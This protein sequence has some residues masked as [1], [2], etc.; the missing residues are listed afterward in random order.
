MSAQENAE[1]TPETQVNDREATG[2]A[3]AQ[4]V[5]G[6]WSSLVKGLAVVAGF[7]A[8]YEL[9][10][11]LGKGDA[12]WQWDVLVSVAAFGVGVVLLLTVGV[13]LTTSSRE[14]MSDLVRRDERRRAQQEHFQVSPGWD[15]VDPETLLGHENPREF[16]EALIGVLRRVRGRWEMGQAPLPHEQKLLDAYR[17]QREV[18]LEEQARRKI[19]RTSKFS[20]FVAVVGVVL[21]VGGYANAWYLTNLDARRAEVSDAEAA[22][23]RD[24]EMQVLSAALERPGAQPVVPQLQSDVLFTIPDLDTAADVLG[25]DNADPASCWEDRPALAL[26]W[27]NEAPTPNGRDLLVAYVATNDCAAGSAWIDPAWLVPEPSEDP[28][29]DAGADPTDGPPSPTASPS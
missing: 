4:L 7:A 6:A 8:T 27:G 10:Q 2:R 29:S 12:G 26:D 19:E 3:W 17:V 1:E 18:M 21:A 9:A 28:E 14:W 5:L 13:M 22:H 11:A 24:M 25:S 23:V 20:T 16:Q 15:I